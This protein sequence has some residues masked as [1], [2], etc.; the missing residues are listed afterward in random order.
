M[1]FA[2]QVEDG[3]YNTFDVRETDEGYYRFQFYKNWESYIG[4]D[5]TGKILLLGMCIAMMSTLISTTVLNIFGN[6]H[7]VSVNIHCSE[8]CYENV[9]LLVACVVASST[10]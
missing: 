3:E 10:D 9:L 8:I 6:I 5:E 2:R 1:G 7:L 4:V